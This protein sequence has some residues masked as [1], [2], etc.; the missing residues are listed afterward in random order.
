MREKRVKVQPQISHMFKCMSQNIFW[1][2]LKNTILSPAVKN[3]FLDFTVEKF[4]ITSLSPSSQ[5][6]LWKQG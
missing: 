2:D 6:Q 3:N 4:F 5:C 1:K